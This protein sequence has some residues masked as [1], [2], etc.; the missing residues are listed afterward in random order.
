MDNLAGDARAL[1]TATA[2]IAGEKMVAARERLAVALDS[3][4]DTYAQ[5]QKKAIQGAKAAD[6]VVRSHPYQTIGV[7]FAVGALAGFFWSRRSS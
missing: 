7:A 4:K 6:K 1:L 2:D 5:V 3:A